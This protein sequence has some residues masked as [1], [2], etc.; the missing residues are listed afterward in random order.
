MAKRRRR[1]GAPFNPNPTPQERAA[2]DRRA[3]ELLRNAMVAPALVDDPYPLNPGDKIMTLRSIRNDPLADMK[4]K[5]QID[6]CDMAA[7]R[8]WQLAYENS[9][10]GGVRAID[11]SKEAV[12]GGR[13]PEMV[14]DVQRKA[15]KDIWLARGKLGSEGH[16]LITETLGLGMSLRQI[17][18]LRLGGNFSEAEYKFVRKRF[19]ECLATLAKLFGYANSD[20]SPSINI[21]HQ[22]LDRGP[23][24]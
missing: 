7:G 10:I 3:T 17:V 14:T 23:N 20:Y 24:I 19:R 1:K 6:D 11:P 2:H 13:M 18:K 21:R 5:N 15:M 4:A 12:D 8:H 16:I 9:E 22:A